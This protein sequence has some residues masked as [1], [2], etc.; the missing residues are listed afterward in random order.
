MIESRSIAVAVSWLLASGFAGGSSAAGVFDGPVLSAQQFSQ[1]GSSWD[2]RLTTVGG[3]LSTTAIASLDSETDSLLRLESTWTREFDDS[4]HQVRLGDAVSNPG[5]WG[6]AVRFAG[7]QFGTAFALRSDL[8]AANRLALAG[9]AIVPSTIDAVL[10]ANRSLETGLSRHGLS[11]EKSVAIVDANSVSF[12]A[13][14][15]A[16]RTQS[17]SQPLVAKRDKAPV[18]CKSFSMGIGRARR[19]YAIASNSY[20][21]WFANTTVLCATDSGLEIE[22]HGEYLQEDLGIVGVE[23][24]H[25]VG[26]IGDASV[27]VA[28]SQ[29]VS[30]QY[31]NSQNEGGAGWLLRVGLHHSDQRFEMNLRARLQSQEFRELGAQIE[32]DSVAQ[33]LLASVGAKLSDRN[34]VAIMY[35]NETT[36]AL[37]HT[38]I[39]AMKQTIQLS[40]T[41]VLSLVA[42]RVVSEQGDASIKLSY[43]R[44]L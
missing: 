43:S 40:K 31:V 8:I 27:A 4:S 21:P 11:L 20:G 35:T 1:S 33:R 3:R 23:V 28:S 37:R 14:D 30:S 18:G 29:N 39:L 5:D 26:A 41:A 16:G 19:D 12:T 2:A 6:S 7:V 22:A 15:S 17:F 32:T 25:P 24:T 13:R 9:V 10:A 36:Y 38:D 42:N 44:A 34:S